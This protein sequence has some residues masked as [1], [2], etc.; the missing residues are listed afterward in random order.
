MKVGETVS[1][2]LYLANSFPPSIIN[3]LY[4]ATT[5]VVVVVIIGHW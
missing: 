2:L 3:N 5:S 1:K 4:M